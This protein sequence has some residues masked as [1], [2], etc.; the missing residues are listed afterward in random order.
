M[1]DD[2]FGLKDRKG[3]ALTLE[4]DAMTLGLIGWT[5]KVSTLALQET[6]PC[7]RTWGTRERLALL[8]LK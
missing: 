8:C 1:D 4:D 6:T 2:G 3:S 7:D 5:K